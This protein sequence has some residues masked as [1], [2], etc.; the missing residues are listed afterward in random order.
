MLTALLEREQKAGRVSPEVT[1]QDVEL[2]LLMPAGALSRSETDERP[3]IARRPK[4]IFHAAFSP[5]SQD[6]AAG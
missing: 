4:A 6:G 2:A 3:A 1:A 5:P